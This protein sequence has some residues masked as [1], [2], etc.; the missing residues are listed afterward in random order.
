MT[1]NEESKRSAGN[2][3]APTPR[4][5]APQD[6]GGRI[7]GQ[8][9]GKCFGDSQLWLHEGREHALPDFAMSHDPT[10]HTWRLV[11]LL[12]VV[13]MLRCD[14]AQGGCLREVQTKLNINISIHL[15]AHGPTE[16][17]PNSVGV[18]HLIPSALECSKLE[19]RLFSRKQLLPA[20]ELLHSWWCNKTRNSLLGACTTT[21]IGRP[22]IGKG[23]IIRWAVQIKLGNGVVGTAPLLRLDFGHTVW[24]VQLVCH[25]LSNLCPRACNPFGAGIS[26]KCTLSRGSL[27]IR[28]GC[29]HARPWNYYIST[30]E[31][32]LEDMGLPILVL[33]CNLQLPGWTDWSHSGWRWAGHFWCNKT[34]NSLLGAC[35]TTQIC[36]PHIGKGGIIRWAVQIK[37]GNGVVGTAPLLRLDFGHTVWLVQLV[38]HALSNLCPRACNP[39][40]AGISI[41]CTLSRGSFAIRGGCSHARPWN[42]YISTVELNLEDMGLPILVLSCNLQLPGRTDWS[43]WR[44]QGWSN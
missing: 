8:D 43:G 31:L 36:R 28:G 9:A 25:A 32:N 17:P 27:A 44:W 18:L 14:V 7:P 10:D 16:G 6:A 38:C 34:R 42:Y 29:S 40:G 11:A 22:H 12:P 4:L 37:L 2:R 13:V 41:K 3:V 33:S 21:Q 26:I 20:T 24:L 35:T 15:Q 39:F 23:G 5:P 1:A 19:A 30:V